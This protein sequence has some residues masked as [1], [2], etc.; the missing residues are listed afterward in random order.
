MP[1]SRY[2]HVNHYISNYPSFKSEALNDAREP[3][4]KQDFIDRLEAEG[5]PKRLAHHIASKFSHDA[6]VIYQ[7]RQ[8]YDETS[9]EH[10]E[11]F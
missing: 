1:L 4:I 5:V 10:Y 11:Q 2:S 7:S 6:L 3:P 8:D 9:T